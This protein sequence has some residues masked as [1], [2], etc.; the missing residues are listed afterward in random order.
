MKANRWN[1]TG[2]EKPDYLGGFE[3]VKLFDKMLE[4]GA[5]DSIEYWTPRKYSEDWLAVCEEIPADFDAF[6]WQRTR[7]Y[8]SRAGKNVGFATFRGDGSFQFHGDDSRVLK[9]CTLS[10]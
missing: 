9:F 6:D 5:V 2:I 10:K 7:I 1:Y 4:A 8:F 3:R